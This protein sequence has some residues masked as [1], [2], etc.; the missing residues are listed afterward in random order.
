MRSGNSQEVF[1]ALFNYE[2]DV[3]VLGELP[4]SRDMEVVRLST[5]PLVAF[6]AAGREPAGAAS[7]TLRQLCKYPLVLR[8]P[9]SNTRQ[10]L[11]EAARRAGIELKAAIEAEGREAIRE[12]VASGAGV[13][14]VSEAEFGHDPRLVKIPIAGEALAMDE[15]LICLRERAGGKVVKAFMDVAR[16]LA[17]ETDAAMAG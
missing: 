17:D 11:E 3:G 6:A 5:T 15:A 16:K 9:G 12:I 1:E 4:Q 10:K 14:I 7:L 13:G 8:E 2:A